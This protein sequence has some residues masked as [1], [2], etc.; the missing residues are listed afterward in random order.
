MTWIIFI[1]VRKYCFKIIFMVL[2]CDL[3]VTRGDEHFKCD[4]SKQ[5]LKFVRII[6]LSTIITE[7]CNIREVIEFQ[8]LI[9]NFT[10]NVI[11]E[12]KDIVIHN[13]LTIETGYNSKHDVIKSLKK[14]MSNL[15]IYNIE[16]L[17]GSFNYRHFFQKQINA[18]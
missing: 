18:N 12:Y 16:D 2:D 3:K 11:D 1:I 7:K 5:T 9:T 10:G 8:F 4:I 6:P 17:I 13:K 14:F 15:K